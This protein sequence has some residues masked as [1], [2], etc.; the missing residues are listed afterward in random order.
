[1]MLSSAGKEYS[2]AHDD[3]VQNESLI[4]D[5]DDENKMPNVVILI[6]NISRSGSGYFTTKQCLTL[7]SK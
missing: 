4:A 5:E 3:M 2:N 6:T 1:M 7:S